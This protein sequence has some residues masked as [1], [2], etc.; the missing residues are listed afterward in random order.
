MGGQT[1]SITNFFH[2]I[3]DIVTNKRRFNRN[4]RT[5]A[6]LD[7]DAK[8]IIT[9]NHGPQQTKFI[10]NRIST[11]KYSIL[12]FL[13]KFLFEQFRKYSNIFFLCIAVLQVNIKIGLDYFI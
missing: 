5:A 10:T 4:S 7:D 8:R 12:S 2:Q 11:N 3:G 6:H 13:P 1:S 9:I